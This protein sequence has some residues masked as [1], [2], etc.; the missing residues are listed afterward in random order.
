MKFVYQVTAS[1]SY[2]FFLT[3]KA[4]SAFLVQFHTVSC[5]VHY[6]ICATYEIKGFPT[7]LGWKQ[8]ES[9][10]IRG[11]CLNEEED[12]DPDSVGE[13]LDLDMAEIARPLFDWEIEDNSTTEEIEAKLLEQG[14]KAAAKKKAW[15]EHEPHTHN[16]R[17]HN[18]A[19]SLVFA[20]KSQLFQTLTEDNKMEPKRKRALVD[21]LD[22]L[23]WATPQSW[24]LRTSLIREL[25]YN[26]DADTVKDRGDLESLINRDMNRHH[27]GGTTELWGFVDANSEGSWSGKMFRGQ[28]REQLAKDDKHWTKT[29]THSQPAK[30][31]TCGLW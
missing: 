6:H 12:I 29:C 14:R 3:F 10:A 1:L 15:H 20:V 26:M 22:L 17:Y 27:S 2:A 25:Q 18:A 13:M 11:L 28:T 7:I 30:G 4:R 31:F 23:D 16:D 8:G 19:L 5:D 21:F 24:R 9:F